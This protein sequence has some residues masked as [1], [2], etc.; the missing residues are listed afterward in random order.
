MGLVPREITSRSLRAGGAQAL[1]CARVDTDEI[2]L[3]GRWKSG[4]MLRYLS[5]QA[6]PVMDKFAQCTLTGGHFTVT[7]NL[8]VPM[9]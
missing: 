1:L 9:F 7:P 2:K 6:L 5:A 4:A 3:L 8:S